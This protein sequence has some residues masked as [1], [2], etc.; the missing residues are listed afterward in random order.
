MS[1]IVLAG[2]TH[3]MNISR[4]IRMGPNMYMC[5][6]CVGA[7]AGKNSR[8]FIPIVKQQCRVEKWMSMGKYKKRK[9]Y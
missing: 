3:N 8:H 1:L 5:M 2:L 4:E 6:E 7:I 9:F